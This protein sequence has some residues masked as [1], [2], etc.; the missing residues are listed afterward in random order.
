MN[1]TY[2]ILC[3]L[4]SGVSIPAAQSCANYNILDF[5]ILLKTLNSCHA[6]V[7]ILLQPFMQNDHSA[8]H[9]L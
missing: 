1:N 5:H 9:R 4:K 3:N 7:K 2:C 8:D 6:V